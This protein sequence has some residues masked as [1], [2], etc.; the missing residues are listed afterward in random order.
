MNCVRCN[1]E[2][3]EYPMYMYCHDCG[4]IVGMLR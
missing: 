4:K 2:I 1:A 3:G